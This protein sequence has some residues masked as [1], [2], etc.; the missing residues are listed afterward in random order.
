M[1]GFSAREAFSF[2]FVTLKKHA[3][4]LL[5]P[6]F[7]ISILSNL[8]SFSMDKDMPH[9]KQIQ[10]FFLNFFFN[11]GHVPYGLMVTILMAIVFI[12]IVININIGQIKIGIKAFDG[13]D[14]ALSWNIYNQFGKGILSRYI[15]GNIVVGLIVYCGML[16][17]I[18]PGFIFSLM[19]LFTHFV[20][21]EKRSK[22][23]EALGI[24]SML[25]S[26]IKWSLFGYGLFVAFL[27]LLIHLP[28]YLCK[29]RL[30]FYYYPLKIILSPLITTF[31][32]LASLYIYKNISEQEENLKS[33]I[34]ESVE[35]LPPE[36]VSI[37]V[38]IG[39]LEESKSKKSSVEILKIFLISLLVLF[40]VSIGYKIIRYSFA[41]PKHING[42][43]NS[44]T[45]ENRASF[46]VN[47]W[48]YHFH[49]PKRGD[50][51]LFP[52]P[53]N[54]E[55]TY[56][57]RIIGLPGESIEWKD[58]YVMVNGVQLEEPYLFDE[59]SNKVKNTKQFLPVHLK[60]DEYFVM[61]DNRTISFDSRFFGPIKKSS[62][63]GK[64]YHVH[65]P[66]E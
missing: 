23:T 66:P 35:P 31:F 1:K 21:V 41:D 55:Q 29:T 15:L 24:S 2:A 57:K 8:V 5:I 40:V 52:V 11:Q 32:F 16:F 36:L 17:F 22:I 63:L 49:D 39:E 14:E 25:T 10:D 59:N 3:I 60:K 43:S 12:F 45:I 27:T 26:G 42:D 58:F 33:L 9:S 44:P 30:G 38:R 20:L 56:V 6:T 46:L 4:I 28:I 34:T 65:N 53:T 19:Y 62:I 48:Y 61:G 13:N 54:P 37:G 64:V 51:I 7:I 47:R 18:I 50:F